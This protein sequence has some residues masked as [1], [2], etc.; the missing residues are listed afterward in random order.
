MVCKPETGAFNKYSLSV[1]I[2]SYM[3]QCY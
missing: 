3:N 2:H 1:P